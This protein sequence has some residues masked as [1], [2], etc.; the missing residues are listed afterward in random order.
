MR[1]PAEPCG[2]DPGQYHS[3]HSLN[4]NPRGFRGKWVRHEQLVNGR[5]SYRRVAAAADEDE[6]GEAFMWYSYGEWRISNEP[7]AVGGIVA[8]KMCCQSRGEETSPG[9][10]GP[11]LW[12][13]YA[14]LNGADGPA[15]HAAPQLGVNR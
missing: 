12:R 14:T 15:W 4:P 6:P 13:M 10:A 8:A 1:N 3:H 7:D 5:P 9:E 11:Q 2:P